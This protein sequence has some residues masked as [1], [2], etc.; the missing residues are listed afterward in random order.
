[1]DNLTGTSAEDTFIF[2]GVQSNSTK[3]SLKFDV[4]TNFES[5]DRVA[6]RDFNER[7]LGSSNSSRIGRLQGK[8]NKLSAKSLDKVLGPDFK[9]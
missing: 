3:R 8:A 9:G 5:S 7:V 4:I 2:R 6:F 1:R